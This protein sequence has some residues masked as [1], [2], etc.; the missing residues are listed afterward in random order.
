[1]Q[2]LLTGRF[3]EEPRLED[4]SVAAAQK[5]IVFW[6]GIRI[7]ECVSVAK[8]ERLRSESSLEYATSLLKF[9]ESFR[10]GGLVHVGKDTG[11]RLTQRESKALRDIDHL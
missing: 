2:W 7:L 9:R 4:V 10:G 6:S 1:M 11:P 5:D 8:P 3:V